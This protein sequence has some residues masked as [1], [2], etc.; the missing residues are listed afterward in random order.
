[1]IR[2]QDE[3]PTV[4]FKFAEE[5]CRSRLIVC[6]WGEEEGDADLRSKSVGSFA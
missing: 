5:R 4:V 1:M 3:D 6:I 2:C